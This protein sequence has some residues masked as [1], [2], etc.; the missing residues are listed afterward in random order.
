MIRLARAIPYGFVVL[1]VALFAWGALLWG[2]VALRERSESALQIDEP[3]K[4]FGEATAGSE[5][6]IAFSLKNPSDGP[7]QVAGS[8]GFCSKT[9]CL[10]AQGLPLNISA[11]E[12]REVRLKVKTGSPGVFHGKIALYVAG[13]RGYRAITL[14]VNG[15][16]VKPGLS[17][18]GFFRTPFAF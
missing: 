18:A 16:V 15:K 11:N 8:D 3:F 1:S 5:F 6:N 12:S 17:S 2:K 13:F 7:M 9:G 14:E 4:T 10:E